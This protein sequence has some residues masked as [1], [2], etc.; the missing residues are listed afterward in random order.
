VQPM[1]ACSSMTATGGA[2]AKACAMGD[3]LRRRLPAGLIVADVCG[4]RAQ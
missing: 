1:H 4:G 3:I 2:F